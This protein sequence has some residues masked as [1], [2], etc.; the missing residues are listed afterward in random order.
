[1]NRPQNKNLRPTVMH[2]HGRTIAIP[3]VVLLLVSACESKDDG[4]DK[5]AN[6]AAAG[7]VGIGR[8]G[9]SGGDACASSCDDG[10]SCT[11][12]SCVGTTC[13]HSIGPNEG[14]TVCPTGQYCTVDKGCVDAPACATNATC[15]EYWEGDACKANARCDAASSVCIFDAL[16][17]DADKHLPQ[18]C[19][20]DDC[21]DANAMVHP[22]AGESCNGDDD[23]CNGTIDEETAENTPICGQLDEC[24]SGACTCKATNLCSGSCVDIRTDVEH[25]GACGQSCLLASDAS[26][27]RNDWGCEAGK[28]VCGGQVCGTICT[29]LNDDRTN[30]GTCGAACGESEVC[31]AGVCTLIHKCTYQGRVSGTTCESGQFCR[32]QI[33]NGLSTSFGVACTTLMCDC[34]SSYSCGQVNDWQYECYSP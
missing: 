33:N 2:L 3:L 17:K 1:M 19:G 27:L 12:D 8:G 14:A 7:D 23:N 20:G 18:V 6:A 32:I 30:C 24:K 4:S 28:C 34:P 29:N 16:D 15:V 11:I 26:A 9:A 31:R 21:N 10:Y 22:G 25:C 5:G 13:R